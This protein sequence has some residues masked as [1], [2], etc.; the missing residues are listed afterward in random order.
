MY[1]FYYFVRIFREI[2]GRRALKKV[3][4]IG[5]VAVVI[6]L[7]LKNNTFAYSGLEGDDTYTDP[8]NSIFQVY[9][10]YLN[11][12][13]MRLNN[14]DDD[15]VADLI[16]RLTGTKQYS[17]VVYYGNA[18]YDYSN[19][20]KH[21]R[22]VLFDSGVQFGTS[23]AYVAFHNMD[24]EY[25]YNT[26]NVGLVYDFTDLSCTRSSLNRAIYVPYILINRYNQILVEVLSNKTDTSNSD[27]V[28]ALNTQ[29]TKIQEQTTAIN[30]QTT[31]IEEQ[32]EAMTSTDYDDENVDIDTSVVDSVDQ[33]TYTGLFTTVFTSF[34][35]AIS[36]DRVEYIRVPIPHAVD[37]IL[38]PSNIV[39]AH[40]SSTFL[41]L[42]Q[43]FWFYLFGFYGFKFVNNLIV[44]IKEGSILDGYSSNDVISS[45]MM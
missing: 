6:M 15:D 20:F 34:N 26:T 35:N 18:E 32:T 23:T 37:D 2:F 43:G 21:M 17:F 39:S 30:N 8:N 42:I 11:D 29:T 38:I 31:K 3:L 24:C 25:V 40:I 45:D 14:S 5:I 7:L 22:V 44:K 28:S 27:I 41:A 36:S 1:Y 10:G 13:A 4:I 19:D 33:S 12:F 16:D 9:D